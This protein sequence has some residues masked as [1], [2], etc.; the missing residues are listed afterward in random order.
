MPLFHE[1]Q[2]PE[3]ASLRVVVTG[4]IAVEL[5]WALHAAVYPRF[6]QDHTALGRIYAEVPRLAER[7]RSF[8]ESAEVADCSGSMELVILAHHGGLLFSLDAEELVGRLPGLCATVPLDLRL[9]S[10]SPEDRVAVRRRLAR[11]RSS[12][13]LASRYT[14]LVADTWSA[15][16]ADWLRQGRRLV[17]AAVAARRELQHRGA[18]WREVADNPHHRKSQ[19][20]EDLV[21]SLGPGGVLAVVPAY[22]AHLGSLIDLPGVV[23]VGVALVGVALAP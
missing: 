13:E 5:D 21:S 7:V 3:D 9:A 1:Q 6:Q 12:P 17:E 16:R 18:S 8:W 11:L 20:L 19:A 10:E 15:V 4:S 22:F 14:S 23:L 2:A